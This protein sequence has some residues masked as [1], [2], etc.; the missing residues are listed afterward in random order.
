MT[1]R[2]FVALF[3]MLVVAVVVS[4][5]LAPGLSAIVLVLGSLAVAVGDHVVSRRADLSEAAR[6][7]RLAAAARRYQNGGESWRN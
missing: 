3:A 6:A 2:Q 5:A 4:Y 7:E 1:G